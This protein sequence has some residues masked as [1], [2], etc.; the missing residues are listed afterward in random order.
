MTVVHHSGDEGERSEYHRYSDDSG[1]DEE[2]F[3]RHGFTL[4]RRGISP[5]LT[6]VRFD[7]ELYGS[8]VP[9]VAADLNLIVPAVDV[10]QVAGLTIK[11]LKFSPAS[12][13]GCQ[14]DVFE[15]PAIERRA[16]H[17]KLSDH[18]VAAEAVCACASTATLHGRTRAQE[19]KSAE[20]TPF[21]ISDRH[22][23]LHVCLGQRSSILRKYSTM[24]TTF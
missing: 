16:V 6:K 24:A 13:I 10:D 11:P 4:L 5:V 22:F 8:F 2:L 17:C 9:I 1:D 18:P 14:A 19:H 23:L 20:D 12:R 3:R 21:T 7:T 15:A